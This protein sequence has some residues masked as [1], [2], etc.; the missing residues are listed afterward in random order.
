MGLFDF[1]KGKPKNP[2]TGIKPTTEAT[3]EFHTL[4]IDQV[5]RETETAISVYFQI[6]DS[7]KETFAY[8]AG[9]Y[10][11]LRVI[12][13][14]VTWLRS[15]SLSSCPISDSFMRIGIKKK[16]GGAISGYLINTLQGGQTVE[17]FPPLGHFTPI[18]PSDT[19]SWI[20]YAGGSGITPIISIA[21]YLLTANNNSS[22]GLLYA[23]KTETDI[24]YLKELLDLKQNFS[25][26]FHQ[27]FIIDEEVQNTTTFDAIPQKGIFFADDYAGVLTRNFASMY[28]ES[29]HFVCGPTPMMQEV[30]KALL[31]L[32][33]NSSN[34]HIEY[35][36]IEKQKHT[37][38]IEPE[39][40]APLPQLK[41][42]DSLATVKLNTQTYRVVVNNGDTVLNAC[43]NAGLDAPFMCEAGVCTTCRA[44]LVK[45]KV[46]MM[47]NYGLSEGEVKNGFILTCQS[48]PKTPE[49][50]VSYD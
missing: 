24:M 26:R 46:E 16:A 12:H 32:S 4:T 42:G 28:Q 13:E 47:A 9:Q 6:P 8:R 17:V 37:P 27:V 14:G 36:E 31:Q 33:V 20:L 5:V 7:L 43:L 18:L 10:I 25:N 35:F 29:Q 41:A 1:L 49:I 38:A 19:N 34:I 44:T 15:Y 21:K 45:G 48:L 50:E 39:Q 2:D 11:T 22:V 40:I 30:E 23:N 3:K